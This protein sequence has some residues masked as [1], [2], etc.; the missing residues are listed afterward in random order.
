MKKHVGI[1]AA[2]AALAAFVVVGAAAA[3][4]TSVVVTPTNTQGWSTADTRPAGTVGFVADPTARAGLGALQLTTDSTTAAKAQYLHATDTPLSQ[5]SELGYWTKQNAASFA[6]GDPSFQLVACLGGFDTG[7][8]TC[9]GFTTFVFEPYENT[10]QG[11]VISKVWQPWDVDAGQMWSSRSYANGGCSV[12]AGAGG[13][14]FYTLGDIQ[15]MCPDAVVVGFG[16]NVGTYN[17]GYDVETDLVDF[18]GTVYDFEPGA[19]AC[20]NGGWQLA[21]RADGTTFGSQ[22]DCIQYENTGK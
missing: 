22:G 9:S 17:P 13:P 7:T 12:T 19:N 15:T 3:G 11:T 20:K 4:S 16:V 8:S 10:A 2:S 1:V 5:V 18:N 6:Q 14:P 21:K